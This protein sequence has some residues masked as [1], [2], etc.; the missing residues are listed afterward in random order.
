MLFNFYLKAQSLPSPFP[1]RLS[2]LSD[3]ARRPCRR[4]RGTL[5]VGIG[6]RLKE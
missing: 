4:E 6:D 5:F 3:K 1:S 2:G